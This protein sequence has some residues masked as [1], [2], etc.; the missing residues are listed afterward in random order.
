MNTKKSKKSKFLFEEV[1][2]Y[3]VMQQT[4]GIHKE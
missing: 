4:L 3:E 2:Y 1:F